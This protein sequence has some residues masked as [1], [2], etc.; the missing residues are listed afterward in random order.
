MKGSAYLERLEEQVR[1][2]PSSRLFLSLA[3]ELRKRGREEESLA[4]LLDGVER[5]PGFGPGRI[6]L[7]KR[8]LSAALFP[9]AKSEF[10]EALRVSPRSLPARKGLAE[11]Y[12]KLDKRKEAAEEYRCILALDPYDSEAAA[13]LD[14]LE[15][16][17]EKEGVPGKEGEDV[18]EA[19]RTAPLPVGEEPAEDA[20]AFSGRVAA[21]APEREVLREADRAVAEGRYEQAMEMYHAFLALYPDDSQ[22]LQRKEELRALLKLTGDGRERAVERL[23]RLSDAIRDR[24]AAY[25]L[26]GRKEQAVHRLSHL[27]DAIRG[28]FVLYLAIGRKD[29][30][31]NRLTLFLDTIKSRF[32]LQDRR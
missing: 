10:I 24:F 1:K 18:R 19:E 12:R 30:V 7:G 31:V 17:P 9:E 22:V 11:V 21:G 13:C 32:P 26:L 16:A 20:A 14:L 8:Y 2:R 15:A 23:N 29:T 3:E 28:R 25:L 27:S 4:V 6:A 5:N